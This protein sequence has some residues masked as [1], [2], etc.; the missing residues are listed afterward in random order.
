MIEFII[1][2]NIFQV[3]FYKDHPMIPNELSLRAKKFILL[4]FIPDPEKRATA[5]DL[6]EDV[7]LTELVLI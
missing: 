2:S 4:C 3:G 7:F 6:L 1:S 5:A